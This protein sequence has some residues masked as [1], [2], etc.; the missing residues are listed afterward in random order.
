MAEEQKDYTGPAKGD[1]E[2]PRNPPNSMLAPETRRRA[3]A[4]YLGP[5]VVLFVVAVI[6]NI[7]MW[8]ERFVIVMTLHRDFLPSSW[9]RYS[10]T[11]W[12]ISTF[13][14]TIGLFLCLLFLFIRFL[15]M[16]S[17]FEMRTLL[18][19]AAVPEEREP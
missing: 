4:S 1:S 14:G 17:I 12:D 7:G 15:P 8:L 18:P 16:I 10:P 9:G 13:V 19:E 11:I 2:D 3:L 6:V 5:V